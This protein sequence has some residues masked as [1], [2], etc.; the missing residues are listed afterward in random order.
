MFNHPN[1]FSQSGP[2]FDLGKQVTQSVQK[3]VGEPITELIQQ[4]FQK[5]LNGQAI[6]LSR[7]EKA[8]LL[9]QVTKTVLT[10]LLTKLD[11]AE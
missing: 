8:R 3:Q 11:S 10:D 5:T 2:Q 6:V 1:P 4:A 9:R 7:P